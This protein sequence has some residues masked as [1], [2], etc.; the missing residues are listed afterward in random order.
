MLSVLII[1]L[2]GFI[3]KCSTTQKIW[4]KGHRPWC[5]DQSNQ[6][7]C[8]GSIHTPGTCAVHIHLL[9]WFAKLGPELINSLETCLYPIM[10]GQEGIFSRLSTTTVLGEVLHL[11]SVGRTVCQYNQSP[12]KSCVFHFFLHLQTLIGEAVHGLHQLAN[13]K[14][15]ESCKPSC[16]WWHSTII[17]AHYMWFIQLTS[18]G[19]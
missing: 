19:S 11:G 1:K 14:G 13:I 17:T 15:L 8:R 6:L 7:G 2:Y 10:H 12:L 4:R 18:V 9:I 3:F 16:C 5:I